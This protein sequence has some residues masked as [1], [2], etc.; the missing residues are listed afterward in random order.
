[1]SFGGLYISMSGIYANK[2]ALDTVSH[3]IA[4][5]NNPNYVR[6]SALHAD[7][8][9]TKAGLGLEKGTGVSVQQIRQTRDEFLDLKIRR[10]LSTFGYYYTKS[11][12]LEEIEYIFRETEVPDV[13]DSATFQDIMDDFWSSWDELSKEPESLTIRGVLHENAVAFTGT[14]N[15]MYVQLDDLQQ[16]LNKEML[17][18][19]KEVN[20]LLED[21][22]GLN[23]KI[24]IQE[25]MGPKIKSNDLRDMRNADLDRLAELIPINYYENPKGEIVVSLGGRNLINEDFFNPLE[26]RLNE[27][28]LGEIH[29]S[30]TGD[31]ID[32]KGLGELGGYIDARDSEVTEYKER[33]DILVRTLAEEI[34]DLHKKGYGL[35][36]KP[37][38]DNPHGGGRNFFEFDPSN[39]SASIKVNSDLGDF[40]KIAASKSGARGDGEVIRDILALREELLY[41]KYD[42]NEKNTLNI[43]EYYRDLITNLGL[44]RE[45]ARQIAFS[46]HMLI[47]QISERKQEISSVSLDEEMTDMLKYQHSY[48][49]NSRVINAIDEMV[50]IIVN[51]LGLVGR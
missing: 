12:V 45:E 29:F 11:D 9:Y 41:G 32:L 8:S 24:R 27:K 43:D 38:A 10:E 5:V 20:N 28:G 36:E 26:I 14:V 40:N 46:Q 50:E 18:K 39:P 42:T 1:M 19:S 7:K 4:N 3:N 30:D 47:T 35:G 16:N 34:N 31:K 2:K 17:N 21:I 49:A 44:E 37:D 25:S 23:K 48:I 22:A 13:L 15:H 33:L 6:Q 51:K